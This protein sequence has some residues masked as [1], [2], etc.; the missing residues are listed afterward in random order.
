[1]NPNAKY[2]DQMC[3]E[4]CEAPNS[5]Y[6]HMHTYFVFVTLLL[7]IKTEFFWLLLA[8]SMKDHIPSNYYLE[9]NRR[10]DYYS[11]TKRFPCIRF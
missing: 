8:N 1:M 9:L 11:R 7:H 5:F 6:R 3:P 10:V 2:E 4:L